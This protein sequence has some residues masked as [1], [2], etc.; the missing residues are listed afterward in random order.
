M[1]ARNPAVSSDVRRVFVFALAAATAACS[2][3]SSSSAPP[4]DA[5]AEEGPPSIEGGAP[6]DA[7]DAAAEAGPDPA[8]TRAGQTRT[9]PAALLDTFAAE[10]AGLEGAARDARAGQ[11][12][13]DVAAAGGTPLE[14]ETSDR[15]VFLAE[16]DGT[17]AVT[18]SLVGFDAAK[19]T[20]MERV[21]GTALSV[22]DVSIP[23]G[24]SFEY[25]LLRDGTYLEDPLARNVV[26][27]GLDRGAVGELNAVGHP[28]A[29]P[30]ERGRLVSFGRVRATALENE[31][32]VY[33][34]LPP[35]YD[36]G[37]C[38][39]FP[40]VFF[41]DGNE[42]LTRG[43]FAGAADAL[44]AKRPELS[45][46]LVFAALP[47]QDVR[48]A[49]YSFG[50]GGKGDLYVDFLTRDLWPRI[51]K[52]HRVCTAKAA[53]GISGASLGG[54]ISTFAAFE[55][56]GEWG[57]VGAQSA[58]YFWA[59][60]GM[61]TRAAETPKIPVRFYLDSGCPGDN[62][63]V[64]DEMAETLEQKG[65]DFVRI[66]EPGALHV[67]SHWHARLGGML[68]HFRDGLTACD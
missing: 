10:I 13:A 36:D 17:W 68:T 60:K 25:K 37:T 53:R 11:L 20:P 45:A 6:P 56:P 5:G 26:W 64:T 66:K 21:A 1:E 57:W 28:S 61:I 29:W 23:R 50:D 43:D 32:P 2:S 19:A 42:S 27:D 44:Y 58:S 67:W 40:S 30:M 35:R 15:V 39:K 38:E 24:A 55:A 65:Y 3:A 62:C 16:G 9:A 59:E 4:A 46:V 18:T 33:V 47:S 12:L 22:A 51:R 52:S 48:M 31:R 63:E 8:C 41:H 34:Y 49:E 54:L 14:D 7:G